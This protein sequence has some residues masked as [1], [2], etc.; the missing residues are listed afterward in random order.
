M[1][2]LTACLLILLGLVS[3]C[4]ADEKKVPLKTEIPQEVLAGT[5]PDVLKLL[6]PGLELLE[7]PPEFLVPEGTVNLALD[8]PVTASDPDPILGK[9]EQIT[10]GRKEGT[11]DGFVE[12]PPGLQWVQ[13]DLG[14]PAAIYAIYVWHYFREARGYHAV[15]I[16]VADDEQF[17]TNVQTVYNNDT[18]AVAKMGIGKNRPYIETHLGLLVD[19]QGATGRYVRLYSR[20]NTANN[21]NHYV[22]VEVFGKPIAKE[23]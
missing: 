23:N 2:R 22:E 10:D 6:F 8:R 16:Q 21:L 15:I 11:E 7:V 3:R 12:L 9:L 5:P 13:I 18:E 20:G 1:I 19:A 17:T 4:V 14:E